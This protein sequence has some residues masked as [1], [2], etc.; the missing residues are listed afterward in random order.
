MRKMRRLAAMLVL[1]TAILAGC[2]EQAIR[3]PGG[4]ST[5]PNFVTT[6]TAVCDPDPLQTAIRIEGLIDDLFD[7]GNQNAALQRW[8]QVEEL[9]TAPPPHDLDAVESN[10]YSLVG[11]ALDKYNQG[12]LN[13][14]AAPGGTAQALTDLINLIFCYTGIDGVVNPI[15]DDGAA[16]LYQPGSAPLLLIAPSGYAGISLPAGTGTVTQPTVISLSRVQPDFPGPL[17]TSLDQHPLY[18]EFNTSSGE[19]F[20]QD[21]TVSVCQ[22][23]N[24][25]IPDDTRLR[26]AHNVPEPN[27]TTIEILP[28]GVG[29]L[30]CTG[31]QANNPTLGSRGGIGA[32]ALGALDRFAGRVF[33]VLGPRELH[34]ATLGVTGTTGTTK[35][36]SPFGA[37]DTLGHL[38]ALSPTSGQSGPQGGT[39]TAPLVVVSTPTDAPM[40]GITVT[41]TVTGG[42]G[43]LTAAGSSTLV[44]SVVTTTDAEGKATV[45]SWVLGTGT[46]TVTAVATP[47][48]L[49]SGID[50]EDG[51][52]FTATALPPVKL[53]FGTQPAT[54][55]A[56]T[57]FSVTVLVQ[58]AQDNTVPA[59]SATVGLALNA[60]NGAVLGG[61]TSVAAV[62][63]V[64][65]F[66][67]LS[68]TKAGTNYTLT[69]TSAP[70][71]AAVSNQFNI[72]AGTASSIVINAGNN[73]TAVE[74]S[75]LGTT[76]GTTAPSVK[77]TDQH[78][79][80][81]AG[82]GVTFQVASGGGSVSPASATTNASGIASTNWTI[83]AGSNTMSAS[84]TALGAVPSVLFSATG[85]SS[86]KTLLDCLPS[87]GS[88][89]E[90]IYPFYAK[91]PGKTLQQVTLYMSANDPAN[92]PTPYSIQLI[93]GADSYGS[94]LATS[95]QTV[96]LNGVS[97]QNLPVNFTFPNTSL[98]NAQDITF[99]FNVLSNPDGA[100][101]TYNTGPC[102]LGNTKC[103]SLPP[104]CGTV[105]ETTG[106]TPLPLSTFRRKGVAVKMIGT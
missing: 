44:T 104:A 15:G 37:V 48:H 32:F 80:L 19:T 76:A 67:G 17:L 105:T 16:E 31:A 2:S 50:P 78:G 65:T 26:L 101:L 68:I 103:N 9:I 45:G 38:D 98:G 106:T 11:Y 74:G 81:V 40:P 85:T 72:T 99:R 79:N 55:A 60:A 102:G 88:G 12:Q 84:I 28:V 69:A 94:T 53:A 87:P 30:D 54:T 4:P 100:R 66:S 3:Q 5:G 36:L 23:E 21:A 97:S 75:T 82:A 59:S 83:V 90:L 47:P 61:T 58:D 35:N 51:L 73:Q 34:A 10:T 24:G 56:G 6:T 57:S 64:A 92:M 7:G 77:L 39:V 13:D 49:G 91:R 96:L 22:P 70:L 62:N 33:A 29:F 18:Y 71:T 52:E 1:G 43:K 86:A 20:L 95:T 14:V 46:N 25:T 89:D 42:G 93:V 8:A 27:F 41:F 63:G